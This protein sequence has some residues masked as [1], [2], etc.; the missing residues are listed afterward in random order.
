MHFFGFGY[1][2]LNCLMVLFAVCVVV[3]VFPRVTEA[4]QNR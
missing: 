3:T 4:L 1:N 2:V